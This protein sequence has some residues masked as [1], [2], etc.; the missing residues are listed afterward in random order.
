M[1]DA[2]ASEWYKIRT[3]RSTMTIIGTVAA[4][5]LLCVLW[6][7]Y[8][9]GYWDGLSAARRATAKAAPAEQPLAVSLPVCAVVL[10]A[11]TLTSEYSCG[12]NRTSLAA[13]PRRLTLFTAKATVTAATMLAAA[14]VSLAV[15]SAAGKAIVGER[16]VPA[17]QG[18]AADVAAHLLW[19]G[20]TTAAI[21]LVTFGLGAVLRSTAGTITVGMAVLIVLPGL[22]QLLPA[23]WDDRIWSAMPGN[24]SNQIAGAPGSS[25]DHGVLSPALAVALLVG[26]VAVVL[27]VG[28]VSFA[29]RDA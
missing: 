23:P 5:M 15:G 10:G 8:V 29:R 9:A 1:I 11:L 18:A 4:F 25:T 16:P 22:A 28:A 21:T 2:F 26:Y 27:A 14:L 19:L 24:L 7:W 12:M 3:V 13:M 6:S 20:L 17:F